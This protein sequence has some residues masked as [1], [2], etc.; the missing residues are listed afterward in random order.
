[1]HTYAGGERGGGAVIFRRAA[2]HAQRG[3][4]RKAGTHLKKKT[5]SLKNRPSVLKNTL[6][7]CTSEKC[8]P[9]LKEAFE[10]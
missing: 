10:F 9:I 5:Q 3:L 6:Q 2:G 4:L 1:M 7:F 8:P